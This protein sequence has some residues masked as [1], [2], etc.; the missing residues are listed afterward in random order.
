MTAHKSQGQTLNKA[1]IDLKDCRGTEAPYVMLSCIRR[2]DDLLIL[3]HFPF[4]KIRCH[5]SQDTRRNQTR[6]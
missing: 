5:P 1:I 4:A 6:I 2:L 3:R